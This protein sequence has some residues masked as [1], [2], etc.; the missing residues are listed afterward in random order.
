MSLP[1]KV[2]DLITKEIRIKVGSGYG[3]E[4]DLWILNI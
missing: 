3:D 1:L 2:S 4:Y